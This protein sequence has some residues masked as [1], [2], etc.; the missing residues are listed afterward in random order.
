MAD[1]RCTYFG[2]FIFLTILYRTLDD[3]DEG[4]IIL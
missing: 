1:K 3:A 2:S 4:K